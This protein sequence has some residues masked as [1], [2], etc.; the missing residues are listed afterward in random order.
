MG[1]DEK[2]PELE[3]MRKVSEESQIIGEFIDWL[4]YEKKIQF[5]RTHEHTD[6]CRAPHDHS[7]WQECRYLI[8]A[9]S[10]G[11]HV[12]F[13]MLTSDEERIKKCVFGPDQIDLVCEYPK[14]PTSNPNGL[15][16]VTTDAEHLIADFFGI[17]MKEVDKERRK[18]L[19]EIQEE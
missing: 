15:E 13:D 16:W 10:G 19:A 8:P 5:Y 12:R 7:Q 2:Y 18:L 17:D 3:K 9:I 11:R 14:E 4:M 1:K 6:A